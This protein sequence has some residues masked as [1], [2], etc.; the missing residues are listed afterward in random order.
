MAL[1]PEG[2][3]KLWVPS[4]CK[5]WAKPAP[6]VGIGLTD[7]SWPSWPPYF[8]LLGE[9]K[10]LV[11]FFF[12]FFN[13]RPVHLFGS[14]L[15]DPKWFWCHIKSDLSTISYFTTKINFSNL[16]VISF[17][18]EIAFVFW[19]QFAPFF[20]IYSSVSVILRFKRFRLDNMN[21]YEHFEN[22]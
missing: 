20:G 18:R 3:K 16:L 12:S 11:G 4:G 9:K 2:E 21:I 14:N 15:N 7:L 6:M 13:K 17:E 8:V 19:V 10:V 1:I 22:W 5:G